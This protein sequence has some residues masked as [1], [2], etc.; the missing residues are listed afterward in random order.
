MLYR[1]YGKTHEKVSLLGFGGMRFGNIK[2]HAACITMMLKA[3][4]G[5]VNYF[6]TAYMYMGGKSES[7]MGEVL[8]K[9][10]RKSYYLVSK[11]PT[12]MLKSKSD[13]LKI[14]DEQL[15]RC[16]TDYFDLYMVHNINKDT[17]DK[18][19]DFESYNQLLTKKREGKIKYLG[20]SF[21]GDVEM[22]KQVVK[23]HD[24][25]FCQL[26]LN[27]FDWDTA[28][29]DE[30][31]DI[32]TKAKLPIVVMEPLRGG[33]LSTLNPSAEKLLKDN[34]PNDTPTSYALRWVAGKENVF[35]VLSGMGKLGHVEENIATLSDYKPLT[36]KEE[37]LSTDLVKA[38]KSQGE[39]G[40]TDCKY[41]IESC[42][43]GVNIPAIFTLYNSYKLFKN[44]FLFKA[45]YEGLPASEK[46]DRCIECGA[47]VK[48]CPQSLDIPKL[49]KQ[50]ESEFKNV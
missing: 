29:A 44:K 15:K 10:E 41:C 18:Y 25:D 48:H 4:Q 16:K 42:P 36:V 39:I 23:E 19:R 34:C 11:N 14:F 26:Q 33:G 40:C 17:I 2:D 43:R 32:A 6:D 30:M 28:K 5:G 38:I 3:A 24:W 20:F 21:H 27:Y 49:L 35:T 50:V 8:Q 13:V 46:A 45:S 31:Y 9:Y 1:N 22:L 47:C 7:A 37:A 12:M